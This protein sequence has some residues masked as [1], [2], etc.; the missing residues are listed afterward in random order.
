MDLGPLLR[1]SG[2]AASFSGQRQAGTGGG[3]V[4]SSSRVPTLSDR[5]VRAPA[6]RVPGPGRHLQRTGLYGDQADLVGDDVVHL[7]GE[8]GA[9]LGQDGLGVQHP[10]VL[11]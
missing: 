6:S 8:L 11:A 1:D 10:L 2:G 4:R 9:F 3:R 7:P 5:M